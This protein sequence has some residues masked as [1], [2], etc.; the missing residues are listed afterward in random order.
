MCDAT[1]HRLRYLV[2]H[3]ARHKPD[4]YICDVCG[5]TF[6]HL[7]KLQ[8]HRNRHSETYN[9]DHYTCKICDKNCES[10]TRYKT[11]IVRFHPDSVPM[12][13]STS[14]LR[15][16]K[17]SLCPKQFSYAWS[18]KKHLEVHDQKSVS[19]PKCFKLFSSDEH[20]ETHMKKKHRPQKSA[21]KPETANSSDVI[22]TDSK[23]P[24]SAL[25]SVK[26]EKKTT[27]KRKATPKKAKTKRKIQNNLLKL[28]PKVDQNIKEYTA[29]KAS[30]LEDS[31]SLPYVESDNA[32]NQVLPLV[33]NLMIAAY[34]R[35]NDVGTNGTYAK[36]MTPPFFPNL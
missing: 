33:N 27:P 36:M 17:C 12:M 15:F 23:P 20:L 1:F 22:N 5:S 10:I 2:Y 30:N 29:V 32:V 18:L 6:V 34:I 3:E 31:Q 19:C 28:Q 8:S 7:S 25:K 26:S 11:H 4:R 16:H 21:D 24:K 14:S 9:R 35:G 13:E